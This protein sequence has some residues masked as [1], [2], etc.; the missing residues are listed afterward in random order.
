M[1][2]VFATRAVGRLVDR[3]TGASDQ[4]ADGGKLANE[5]V[6]TGWRGGA[7]AGVA[8]SL[9]NCTA[10]LTADPVALESQ[11]VGGRAGTGNAADRQARKRWE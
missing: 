2:A 10:V 11:R 4:W 7:A 3:S 8:A 6:C 1:N 9:L 5:A